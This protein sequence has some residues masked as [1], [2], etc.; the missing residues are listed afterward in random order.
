[1][2]D[3][4]LGPP[5]T[6]ALRPSKIDALKSVAS[7][8]V[9]TGIAFVTA[10]SGLVAGLATLA[11]TQATA[12]LSYETLRAASERN[13]VQIEA[14]R[15]SQLEQTSWIEELSGRLE[16][17]QATTE[18]VIKTKV[19]RPA[20]TPVPALAVEPAPKA[21]PLPAPVAPSAL[22]TFDGLAQKPPG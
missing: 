16:R 19:T 5:P 12:R 21:P 2:A 15:Q 14:C 9:A 10:L 4:S 11:E 3:F 22:P 6:I 13:A 1:M 20:A 18:K 17:R 7:G 8:P